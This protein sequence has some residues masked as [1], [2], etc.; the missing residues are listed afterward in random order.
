MCAQMNESIQIRNSSYCDIQTTGE[1]T[2]TIE[3]RKKLIIDSE[4]SQAFTANFIFL[5][6]RKLVANQQPLSI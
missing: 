2:M 1:M 5:S 6:Y 3:T 4:K